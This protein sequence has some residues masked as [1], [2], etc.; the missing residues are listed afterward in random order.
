MLRWDI[1][2]KER[3]QFFPCKFFACEVSFWLYVSFACKIMIRILF[4]RQRVPNSFGI[5][6]SGI[7][8]FK[9]HPKGLEKAKYGHKRFSNGSVNYADIY[10]HWLSSGFSREKNI[11]TSISYFLFL[12]F[13]KK[14]SITKQKRMASWN[15]CSHSANQIIILFRNWKSMCVYTCHKIQILSINGP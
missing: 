2:A 5:P 9:L 1:H 7:L 13:T 10:D 8:T 15:T 3:S 12:F 6:N 14:G 11:F 4:G